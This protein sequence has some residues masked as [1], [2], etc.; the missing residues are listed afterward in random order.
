VP[1]PK[2]C[3]RRNHDVAILV[4]LFLSSFALHVMTAA[5]TVTF[6]DSGDFLMAISTVG[7]CHCPGY[8][9]FIMSAKVF[10]WI[11]PAG[12]LAFR[13]SALSGIF[14]SLTACLIYWVVYRMTHSRI[15]GVVSGVAYAFSYTFWYETVIPGT[16]G[17]NA[18]FFAL[19][20]VLMLRWERML[21]EGQ[22]G[23]ADNALAAFAFVFGLALTNHFSVIFLVPT[24]L[25]FALDTN[26]RE[27]FAL[28][29]ILR[30]AAFLML[31]LLPFIYEPVAAFRGPAYNFGDPSTLTRWF[32][33]ITFYHTRRGLFGYPVKFFPARFWR[34]FPTLVTEFPYFFWLAAV[35][36]AASFLKRN[37]KYALF[38]ILSFLLTTLP[39]MS[40]N[41]I[42]S[43]LRAHFYYPGYLVVALMIGFGAAWIA[44][45]IK[46]WAERRDRF[47]S[48][49]AVGLTGLVLVVFACVSIPVHYGKVDKS[50]YNYARDMAIKM[51]K[52]AEPDGIILADTDNVVFPLKYMQYIEGVSP[53]VRVIIPSA[54]VVPGWPGADLVN[55]LAPP[56]QN[57]SANDPAYA[58]LA[59]LNCVRVPLYTSGITFDFSSWDLEW[60]GL[61][62]R[63]YPTGAP[64]EESRPILVKQGIEPLSNVD[65]DAREA[66]FL[67]DALKAYVAISSG[68]FR[69]AERLYESATGYADKN[70]YV[71]TLYGC[72]TTSFIFDLWGQVLNW[73]GDYRKTVRVMPRVNSINPDFASPS[74]AQALSRCGQ[75]DAA[76]NELDDFL[77]VNSTS[78]VACIEKGEAEACLG[79]YERALSSFKKAIELDSDDPRSHFGLGFALF[80]LKDTKSAA[81]QFHAV[82]D[83]WPQTRWGIEARKFLDE[84]K[85]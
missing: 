79:E 29:N 30:M 84:L 24:F 71:P 2:K 49:T 6:S 68:D 17:L 80:Q 10:S 14:A 35:G 47:V 60:Q 66:I 18:F 74:Y 64:R 7:N 44:K 39:V 1:D 56:G 9:L 54:L 73:L 43:V 3:V 65:S 62:N 32:H 40:Y 72:E 75:A 50:R 42:E 81:E 28:R 55:I 12:S 52:K 11:F 26:W 78:A 58:R 25:F 57:V 23:R 41:Q 63:V 8:P 51:L 20:L 37:K 19:L 27:L 21:S 77:A 22:R 48:A 82:V 13:V 34:Y 70:L 53:D 83:K 31:G 59:K 46:R 5:R 85:K 33:H 4:L 67:P 76:L 15:G 45:L 69:K 36:L 61:L 38:L 16:Y